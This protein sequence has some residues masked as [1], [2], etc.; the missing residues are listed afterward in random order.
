MVAVSPRPTADALADAVST[1]V[2]ADPSRPAD[3]MKNIAS[4]S[5]FGARAVSPANCL[6]ACSMRSTSAAERPTSVSIFVIDDSK[7]DAIFAAAAPT[8]ANANAVLDFSADVTFPAAFP[9]LLRLLSARLTPA[10]NFDVSA[11]KIAFT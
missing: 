7:S 4:A 9:N 5:S 2:A 8:A 10:C 11:S 3:A 6:T 1:S